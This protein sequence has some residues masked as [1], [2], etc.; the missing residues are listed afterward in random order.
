[1]LCLALL[2]CGGLIASCA[3]TTDGESPPAG[4]IT[5]QDEYGRPK[6]LAI[7]FRILAP[8][9]EQALRPGGDVLELD[10][11]DPARVRI[12]QVC[13]ATLWPDYPGLF[14]LDRA[15]TH[16]GGPEL[17]YLEMVSRAYHGKGVTFVY[18][19]NVRRVIRVVPAWQTVPQVKGRHTGS[20]AHNG[21]E[22]E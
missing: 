16:S 13:A 11:G 18:D 21:E 22:A 12:A 2:T 5:G 9:E 20:S 17:E 4:E 15:Y 10:A 7:D 14:V 1:M 19:T 6:I 8:E 3:P